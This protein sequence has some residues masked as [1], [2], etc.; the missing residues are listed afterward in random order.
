MYSM[1]ANVMACRCRNVVLW[2]EP[3]DQKSLGPLADLLLSLV[4][5]GSQVIASCHRS[6]KASAFHQNAVHCLEHAAHYTGCTQSYS[7]ARLAQI[8]IE[9]A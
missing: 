2:I 8:I 5:T 4:L 9:A 7:H 1:L 6:I 3:K